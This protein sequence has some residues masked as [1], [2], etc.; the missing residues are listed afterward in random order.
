MRN[1]QFTPSVAFA[2][3]SFCIIVSGKANAGDLDTWPLMKHQERS[4]DRC[5]G[6]TAQIQNGCTND[7][8]A[9]PYSQIIAKLLDKPEASLDQETTDL[10]KGLSFKNVHLG[11]SYEETAHA[12]KAQS[13]ECPISLNLFYKMEDIMGTR[14][15]DKHG[16]RI[17]AAKLQCS[18]NGD[19][20][21]S[22][23]GRLMGYSFD[24]FSTK[25]APEV[26]ALF[27]KSYPD[28]WQLYC[29]NDSCSIGTF[30]LSAMHQT[31]LELTFNN[32]E[33]VTHEG[34]SGFKYNVSAKT[35]YFEKLDGDMFRREINTSSGY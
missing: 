32:A 17:T 33:T 3:L 14:A 27:K 2:A 25:K 15:Q 11:M 4:A 7:Y 28:D 20:D 34:A 16:Q 31:D 24:V 23:L 10:F 6:Q 26:A 9:A 21:F 8:S 5:S 13:I 22:A 30:T 19:L 1:N 18:P 29:E 12:L 35:R